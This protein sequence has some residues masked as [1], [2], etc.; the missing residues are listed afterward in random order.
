MMKRDE[1]F[2]RD[3]FT[4]VYCG[5]GS[6]DVELSVDHV[7]PRMRGGDHSEGNLVTACVGCNAAKGGLA[8]WDFLATRNEE[9]AHFLA[10]TPYVWSR[11][12]RAI[13]EAAESA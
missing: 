11:L 10:H 5:R 9:R 13:V 3:H 1:V 7:E 2:A 12:R 6:P 4:C 8:A